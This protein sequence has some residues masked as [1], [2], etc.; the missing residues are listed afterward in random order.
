M[1][2]LACDLNWNSSGGGQLRRT[3]RL[4]ASS[5]RRA[6]GSIH[7]RNTA[8]MDLRV[9]ERRL[10]DRSRVAFAAAA[11]AGQP[12]RFQAFERSG[13]LALVTT[14]PGLGFLNSVSGLTEESMDALPAVLAVF[15]AARVS[16]P[17]LV[18]DEPSSALAAGLRRLG[19]VPAPPRPAG[20]IDLPPCHPAPVEVGDLRLTEARTKNE[21]RLFLD[22]LI[23]GYAASPEVSRFLRAEHAAAG[24]RRFLAWRGRTPVAAAAF[25]LHGDVAVIGGAAT[26]PAARRSGAQAAL[27]RYRLD[28]AAAAGAHAAAATAAPDS[29]SARNLARSGFTMHSRYSWKQDESATRAIS[30]VL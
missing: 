6:A 15:T 13:L 2:D 8:K 11:A 18:A 30:D 28:Q 9:A 29:A 10:H 25:S 20:T 24:I 23:A 22:T 7:V 5:L 16:S 19:F 26:V 21:E 12:G 4:P 1:A 14:S 27:L 3:G 17:S